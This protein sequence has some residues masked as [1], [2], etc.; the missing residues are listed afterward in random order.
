MSSETNYKMGGVAET[1]QVSEERMAPDV[2]AAR[3]FLTRWKQEDLAEM[4]GLS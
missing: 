1:V 2:P 4:L 3:A